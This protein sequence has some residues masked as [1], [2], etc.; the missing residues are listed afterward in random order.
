MSP[1]N[2][3]S[4]SH[5]AFKDSTAVIPALWEMETELQIGAQHGQPSDC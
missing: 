4:T 5:S 2:N 3:G 1:T